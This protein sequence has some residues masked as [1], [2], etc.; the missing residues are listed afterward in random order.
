MLL[1]Y[2]YTKN[3]ESM[4]ELK[5]LMEAK[6]IAM[7]TLINEVNKQ[8]ND[9]FNLETHVV[10]MSV[11][12]ELL[13]SFTSEYIPMRTTGDGNCMYNTISIALHGTEEYT[14]HLRAISVYSLLEN[15][16]HMFEVMKPST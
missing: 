6:K 9:I 5:E 11:Q 8:E 13:P 3:K 14:A 10:D 7:K 16:K 2:I 4:E 1:T 15:K 12:E